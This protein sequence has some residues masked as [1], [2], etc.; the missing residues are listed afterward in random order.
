MRSLRANFV[1]FTRSERAVN[2]RFSKA[3]LDIFIS[4]YHPDIPPKAHKD[5]VFDMLMV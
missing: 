4:I 3:M 5:I 2:A 1:Q